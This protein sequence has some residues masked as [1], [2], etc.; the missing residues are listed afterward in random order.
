MRDLVAHKAHANMLLLAAIRRHPDAAADAEIVGLLHHILVANRFWFLTISGQPFVADREMA[1]PASLDSLVDL[2]VETHR[3]E[4]AW[5][6]RATAD[7]LARTLENAMIPG[8]RC[9][10]AQG[11]MQVCMHSHGHRAQLKKMLRRHGGTPPMTDFI[12]WVAEQQR[13]I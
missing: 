11:L 2:Y 6:G 8:G 12:L 3:E 9:T 5:M 4:D 10:V 13:V 1:A 7:D